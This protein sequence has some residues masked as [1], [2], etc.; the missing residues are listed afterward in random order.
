MK[1]ELI[2]DFLLEV[3]EFHL[4]LDVKNILSLARSRSVNGFQEDSIQIL[5]DL[6]ESLATAKYEFHPVYIEAEISSESFFRYLGSNLSL[7]IND[8]LFEHQRST[9]VYKTV[10][11]DLLSKY[12][13]SQQKTADIATA[14]HSLG[15]KPFPKPKEHAYLYVSLPKSQYTPEIDTFSKSTKIISQKIK[16]VIAITDGTRNEILIQGI[17]ASRIKF[18]LQTSLLSA[19]LVAHII[20]V[21]LDDI[22]KTQQAWKTQLEINQIIENSNQTD[23]NKFM[24]NAVRKISEKC[25]E[26]ISDEFIEIKDA[27]KTLEFINACQSIIEML[28]DGYKFEFQPPIKSMV[29]NEDNVDEINERIDRL[30]KL[31]TEVQI[32]EINRPE[33]NALRIKGPDKP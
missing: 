6:S 33:L 7:R 23:K 1:A 31:A 32:L 9:E 16:N 24:T 10:L 15:I 11:N 26:Q 29:E 25:A 20:H 30:H 2:L 3:R 18:I 4:V 17:S 13:S 28:N 27:D 5:Q 12:N 19:T 14:F 22:I 21:S 8:L